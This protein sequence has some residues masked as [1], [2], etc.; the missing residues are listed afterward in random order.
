MIL[1]E[2]RRAGIDVRIEETVAEIVGKRGQVTHVITTK[3][4]RIPCDLL[5][6]AIGIAPNIDFIRASGIACG[7]GVKVDAAMR[8]NAPDIY[9]VG[10]VTETTDATT[11][12]TRVLGQWFPA[13][14]QAR[15]AAYSMLD[16]YDGSRPGTFY[17]ATFLYGL[18]FVSLGITAQKPAAFDH[19]HSYQE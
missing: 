16:Q 3:D 7:Q 2:E 18:D 17:N 8:T 19:T 5:L 6:I 4:T 9:A 1:Q 12:H 14:Q 13:I 11:G 10:D 15:T